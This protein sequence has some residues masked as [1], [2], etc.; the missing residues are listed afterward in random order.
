[1]GDGAKR[2]KGITMCTDCFSIKEVVIL[3]NILKIKFNIDATI[4]TEKYRWRIY[5]NN[6]ELSKILPRILPLYCKEFSI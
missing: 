1:M 5:I 3:I 4:H 2:N 6:N